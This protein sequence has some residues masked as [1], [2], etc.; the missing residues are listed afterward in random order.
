MS[1]EGESAAKL[2]CAALAVLKRFQLDPQV[3]GLLVT[4]LDGYKCQLALNFGRQNQFCVAAR[5][6]RFDLFDHR[7]HIRFSIVDLDGHG[8]HQLRVIIHDLHKVLRSR[9]F[10]HHPAA[11]PDFYAQRGAADRGEH[12]KTAGTIAAS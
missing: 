8:H 9:R 4:Q 7:E 6:P 1:R 10:S 11:R 5:I 3:S 2:S 12:P